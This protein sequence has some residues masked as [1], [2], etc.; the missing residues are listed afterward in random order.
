MA[1][2]QA[3]IPEHCD[4]SSNFVKMKGQPAA[5]SLFDQP[6]GGPSHRHPRPFELPLQL[7]TVL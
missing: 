3:A 2:I 4:N 1:K 6:P 7:H 5:T